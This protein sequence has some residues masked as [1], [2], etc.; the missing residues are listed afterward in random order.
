MKTFEYPKMDIEF[1]TMLDVIA[2]SVD[3]DEVSCENETPR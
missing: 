3:E 2:A 1:F